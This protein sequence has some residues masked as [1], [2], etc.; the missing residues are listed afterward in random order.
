MDPQMI[1]LI[2]YKEKI[3]VHVK[4]RQC[5]ASGS[6]KK[7]ALKISLKI[8][9]FSNF[10][11]VVIKIFNYKSTHTNSTLKFSIFTV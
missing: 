2:F 3:R 8:Y 6:S 10:W 5:H 11:I 9:I 7:L 4:S 1:L